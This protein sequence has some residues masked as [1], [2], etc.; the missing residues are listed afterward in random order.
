MSRN[1]NET[2]HRRA[3]RSGAGSSRRAAIIFGVTVALATSVGAA[4]C[5][6]KRVN[7][8][9]ERGDCY[10]N[11]TCD[12]GLICLSRLCVRPPPA[13]CKKV[14]EK[15]GF[16]SLGNYTPRAVRAEFDTRLRGVCKAANLTKEE[17]D[18]ILSAR[19]KSALSRC[20][21]PLVFANCE[22]MFDHVVKVFGALEPKLV[23]K[24]SRDRDRAM[25]K[26]K[27]KLYTKLDEACVLGATTK[28]ALDACDI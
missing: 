23:Q 21:K 5:A 10:G 7:D 11:G 9:S 20:K 13:D 18:C 14:V 22:R 4:G 1:R 8:G 3:G 25:R 19:D 24:I 2:Q 28:A 27:A 12:E 6:S 17:G 16:L 15:L 26:C